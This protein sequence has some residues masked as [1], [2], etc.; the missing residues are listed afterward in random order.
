VR[1]ALG[2]QDGVDELCLPQPPEAVDAELVGQQMEIG[3]RAGGQLG[4]I[5]NG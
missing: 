5:E 2:H 3:E 4:G 1:G